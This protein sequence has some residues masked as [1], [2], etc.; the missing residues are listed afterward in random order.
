QLVAL[1]QSGDMQAAAGTAARLICIAPKEAVL[2]NFQGIA[3]SRISEIERAERAFKTAIKL[4]PNYAEALGNLGTL[5]SDLGKPDE[6]LIALGKA[7]KL[8]PHL[9]EVNNSMGLV[10]G[11]LHRHKQSLTYFD[12]AISLNPKYVN[13]FNS[14]GLALKELGE[15]DSAID[16][17][18][19]GLE[20]D[21][22]STDI[23]TNLGYAYSQALRE[24]DAIT[25]LE[26]AAGLLSPQNAE[27]LMRLSVIQSQVGDMEAARKNL[28][29]A[30]KADPGKA[31]P[32]R[33][34]STITHY[35]QGDPEIAE[36]QG[37]FDSSAD[38]SD[39][40]VH[41]G[42]GLG[43][44]FEDIDEP[45]KAFRYWQAG[46]SARRQQFTYSVDQDRAVFEQV[47]TLFNQDFLASYCGPQSPS[48]Q[49]IF[50]VG[51]IRSGTTLVEQILSG[52][53]QVYGAG[54]LTFV[55][56]YARNWLRNEQT[57]PA[58]FDGFVD[59][60]LDYAAPA[61][62]VAAR[63]V[64]K[65]PINFLWIGIIKAAFPNAKII[66]LVR[67]PRDIGLSIFKNYFADLG[68]RYAYDLEELA[69][70]YLLYKGIMDHW[71][72]VL[73]GAVYDISYEAV[74]AD[75]EGE[76]RGLLA[77]CDLDWQE[78]IL[79]F[80]K[81]ARVVK[82]ASVLQVRKAVYSSSVK[83][84]KKYEDE[85]APYIRILEKAGALP[86]TI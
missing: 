14:K 72:K 79:Q 52:H 81:T 36:M 24:Q 69:E 37:L 65:M 13:A 10:L 7:L 67:D 57:N 75:L 82:T 44:A 5:L 17:F 42:F 16:V 53:S 1:L 30:I 8:Q 56:D 51:M 21:A 76:A 80:H 6:A 63:V 15:L 78:N 46:N 49:P 38:G 62:R 71:H 86:A 27:V 47:R 26:K 20:I 28:R 12:T 74:V 66:N 68:N 50:V 11:Q 19:A 60:Y 77:H 23:L 48:S 4:R 83:G 61:A 45:Q 84:W 22:N 18:K 33:V 39:T 64:D 32:H 40:R 41:L 55:D 34:L 43:K 29:A 31:E 73:P 35:Q 85:L 54:E 59:Q 70:F 9:P 2:H 58:S 3:L 25:T